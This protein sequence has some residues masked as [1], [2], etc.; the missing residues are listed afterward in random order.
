MVVGDDTV[1]NNPKTK[2]SEI[3]DNVISIAT[4]K[5]VKIKNQLKKLEDKKAACSSYRK[6]TKTDLA[7]IG[8]YVENHGVT[9]AV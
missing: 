6:Y 8:R 9:N 1:Y 4:A 7:E 2:P 3:R 5:K